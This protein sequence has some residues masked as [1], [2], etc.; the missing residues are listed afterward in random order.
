LSVEASAS[1]LL[2]EVHQKDRLTIVRA[3]FPT[4][5]SV[6]ELRPGG[7][8]VSPL[9]EVEGDTVVHALIAQ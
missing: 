6:H 3:Q 9:L 7:T 4:L 8:P 5:M 1:S 2:S